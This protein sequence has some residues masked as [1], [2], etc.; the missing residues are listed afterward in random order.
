MVTN[1]VYSDLEIRISEKQEKGYPVELTLSNEGVQFP[2]GFLAPD[3]LPWIAGVDPVAD[4]Q[5]LSDWLFADDLLKTAWTEARGR[6]PQRRIRLRIDA[7]APELHAIPWEL[8]LDT[9]REGVP[10]SLAASVAT[11]FSRY[12]PGVWEPGSPVSTLPIRILVAIASP[13]F[14]AAQYDLAAIDVEKEWTGFQDGIKELAG[15]GMVNVVQLPQPCTLS[16][17][18]TELKRGYHILHF[19]GHGG[20]SP[21]NDR[22]ILYMADAV[23][24]VERVYETDFAAMLGRLQAGNQLRLVFLASCETATRSSADAFRGFAPRLVEQSLPAVLAMQDL[25]PVETAREF[26]TIFYRQLLRHGQVDLACNEARS[27]LITGKFPGAAIPVLFSRLP[28]NQLLNLPSGSAIPIIETQPFEPETILIPEGPFLMG[29]EPGEDIPAEE[30]P[31]HEVNLPGYRIGKT[32]VTNTQYAEFLKRE[33]EQ[34]APQRAGWFLREPPAGNLDHP[35]VGVGWRDARAYCE[36]LSRDTG[37]TYRLPSEAEWEKAARG[38]D[39]RVYPWGDEWMDG[40]CNVGSDDTAAVDAHPDGASPYGCL[41]M[42]GNVQEWAGSLWGSDRKESSFP[43]PYQAEDGREDPDAD[44]HMARVYRIHRGGSYRDDAEH[45]RGSARGV[46]GADS[47]MPWRG[48]RV[49]MEIA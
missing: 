41:D 16:S 3:F 29:S 5:R 17:L 19:I 36:W 49:V 10:Q 34:D 13:D 39:G 25:V 15:T 44:R 12:L 47:A 22:S 4:G 24:R 2:R 37:R 46:S 38:R 32:P 42:L 1:L 8:L 40:C 30:T 7:S 48:F 31:Q 21:R 6:N 27:A 11:P 28:A 43:Y 20:Y 23:S 45:P 26:T 14:Q 35:V 18:E 9:G 33:R